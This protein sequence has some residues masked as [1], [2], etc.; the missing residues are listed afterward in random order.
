MEENKTSLPENAQRELKPGEK[1]EPLLSPKK[2]YPEV[3]FYSVS[4]GIVMVIIFSAA[5][6][7]LGLKVGQ[8]F[9]AAIP[10]AIIAAG[11]TGAL[12]KKGGLGQNVIIQSIGGCSGAVVA[13]AIFTLP[14]IYILGV[15]VSFMQMFL[16]SLLGGVLGIL[17]LIPFRKYF[18]KEMHGKY[19]F[20]EA[21][22]TTQV[23]VSGEGGG[24]SAKTLVLS[25]LV[26]GL[27]DFI[28]ATFGAWGE[29]LTTTVVSVGQTIA[30]KAKLMLK[31]N[32]GAAVLGL[33]YIVGL[34]YAFIICCG[35]LL[36]WLVIIPLMNVIWGGQV[37]DLMG[38]GITQT[39]GE[40]SADQIF[41]EYARHIGIGGIATA[42]IIG[43]IKSFGVIKSAVR[44]AANEF[45]KKPGTEKTASERTDE[46]IPMKTVVFGVVIALLVVFAFFAF[47]GVVNNIWQAI[48]GLLI[49]G[50]IAF[51][52]TTVAANATAIVGTNPV[53]GMTLMTLIISALILVAVGLKGNAGMAAA[54]IIGGV[55]CTALSMA[56][57]FV[58]DLKIGYW[59]GTTPKK[60]E[61]W[62]FVGTIVAAA[63][64][65]GVMLVLNKTFGF[66]GDNAL[67]APQAN[68]MAAV[69]QP[70]MNGGGAPWL[71]YGIGAV[72][73]IVL[74]ALKIPALAFA[75]GMFI[76]I[77]LNLPLLV[78]GAISWYVSTR[79]KDAKVNAARQDKGTLVASGFIAG[80]AL[81][82]V[83]SAILKF[84]NVDLYLSSWNAQYG[85]AVAIVPYL[86][87]IGFLIWISMKTDKK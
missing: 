10:I 19:P 41:K 11:L 50:I 59:I 83:V 9:E 87:L 84:A 45:T 16:S 20:P 65:C 75:L 58:T 39:I 7:Y 70:M 15:E 52:F 4:V 86:A 49:V 22:A 76:P 13:G 32:T 14:A 56:G 28:I 67:V 54:L 60:Q 80:G 36:V 17:F 63:T 8:V 24:K 47:G 85:E 18:V 48:I 61:A 71:L 57:S 53:S 38:T 73:A 34:K 66:T 23:L 81:M 26:G 72:I 69:I 2:T 44:L 40:M 6:A 29:T 12:G 31:L 51:L 30:D 62:K 68:A 27:Y 25:G 3:T 55:V 43:I 37:I 79:S 64:V 33:G 5:A 77:D 78:G 1:Y 42:G 46:D 35:S 74:T 82:G 21:T